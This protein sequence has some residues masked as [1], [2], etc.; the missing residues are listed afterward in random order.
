MET[1]DKKINDIDLIKETHTYLKNMDKSK[2]DINTF[3][4]DFENSRIY[5][6]L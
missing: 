1:A 6:N 2:L 3:I 5:Q 4:K